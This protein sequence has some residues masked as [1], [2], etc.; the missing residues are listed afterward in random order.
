MLI[1]PDGSIYTGPDDKP[2]NFGGYG[3]ILVDK[4]TGRILR[5]FYEPVH[6]NDPQ[7]AELHGLYASIQLANELYKQNTQTQI[8]ILCDCKNAV[9]Y[10]NN[11]Y[12]IPRK[13]SKIYQYIREE[14]TV[15]N[16]AHATIKWI[17]GHTNNPWNE[18]ADELAK[19]ATQLHKNSPVKRSLDGTPVR[20]F[21]PSLVQE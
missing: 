6:T 7:K 8:T 15:N 4:E 18:E 11:K 2:T 10:V 19:L 3:G 16:N 17:P 14:L 12:A 9:K 5:R 1:L 20:N 21:R 13:Y